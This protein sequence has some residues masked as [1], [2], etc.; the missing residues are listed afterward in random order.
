MNSNK[1]NR[2]EDPR[3]FSNK[4]IV[5]VYQRESAP[6]AEIRNGWAT[7]GQKNTL[8]GLTVL[9]SANLSDGTYIPRGSVAYIKEE[10]LHTA[11]WAAKNLKSDTVSGE[12][13]VVPLSEVEYIDPPLQ[14]AA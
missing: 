4:L 6:R 10:T 11:A 13:I 3:S 12:F 7:V 8:K 9:V 2:L 5:E 1:N 14:P